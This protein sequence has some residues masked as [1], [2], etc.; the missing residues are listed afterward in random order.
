M[1]TVYFVRT[2]F[3]FSILTVYPLPN[4]DNYFCFV[5]F[6]SFFFFR[7][8][9]QSLLTLNFKLTI[10]WIWRF[11]RSTFTSYRNLLSC[12][13]W[14]N[15]SYKSTF[16]INCDVFLPFSS[17]MFEKPLDTRILLFRRLLARPPPFS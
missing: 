5:S 9:N 14:F 13:F 15:T 1:S 11:S 2:F 10:Q 17:P 7:K 6:L 4:N 3:D 8:N 16:S 12:R